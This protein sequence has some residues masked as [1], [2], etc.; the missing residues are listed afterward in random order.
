MLRNTIIP[1][2]WPQYDNEDFYFQQDGAPP[3]YAVTVREF[4]DKELP[5]RWIG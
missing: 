1:Q 4:P 3:H 2:L 5:H